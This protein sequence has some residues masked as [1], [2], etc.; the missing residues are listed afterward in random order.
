METDAE[1]CRRNGWRVGMRLRMDKQGED[2]LMIQ[3][4]AI[5]ETAVMAKLI[6]PHGD[7]FASGPE[8]SDWKLSEHHW[9]D[10]TSQ[11]KIASNVS[12]VKHI[13]ALMGEFGYV[14]MTPEQAVGANKG[15]SGIGTL[16]DVLDKSGSPMKTMICGLIVSCYHLGMQSAMVAITEAADDNGEFVKMPEGDF[17]AYLERMDRMKPGK[18]Q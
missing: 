16:L 9:K 12:A 4:T 6:S 18:V 7:L 8:R 11:E 5:G 3:I 17:G 10:V 2:P 1:I 15:L 14:N 13:T